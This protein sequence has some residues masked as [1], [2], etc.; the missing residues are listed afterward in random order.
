[1]WIGFQGTQ[2][3]QRCIALVDRYVM[4]TWIEF[5]YWL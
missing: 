2:G 4:Q 5:D 3:L 1:M